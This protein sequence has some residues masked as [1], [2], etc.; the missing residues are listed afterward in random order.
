[1]MSAVPEP[2]DVH[3]PTARIP[4]VEPRGVYR[5]AG[6]RRTGLI[7]AAGSAVV[8]VGLVV[9]LFSGDDE[10]PAPPAVAAASAPVEPVTE[11]TTGPAEEATATPATPAATPVTAATTAPVTVR[12][13][14]PVEWIAGLISAVNTL[15]DQDELDDD[16]AEALNRR[17]EQAANRLN[18]GDVKGASRKIDDFGKKLAGLRKD[19]DVSEKTYDL[20]RAAAKK[21]KDALPAG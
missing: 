11:A 10:K 9:W 6:P 15:E 17:L 12:E 2:H 16:D 18:R 13:G 1:M 21:V 14:T 3:Q 8:L 20:L 5:A 7:A 19:D 4:V